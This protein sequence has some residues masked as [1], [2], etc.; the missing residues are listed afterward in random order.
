MVV[1]LADSPVEDEFIWTLRNAGINNIL[2]GSD[3]PQ[4]TLKQA[5][6]ALDRLDLKQEEK[7]EILFENSR[8]LLF[9]DSN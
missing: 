7:N 1:L 8:R 3:F 2:L 4:Y 6:D 5:V 9:P